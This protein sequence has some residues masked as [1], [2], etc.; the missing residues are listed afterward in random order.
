MTV[1]H[2]RY[3]RKKIHEK[4]HTREHCKINPEPG[5]DLHLTVFYSQMLFIMIGKQF[6]HPEL[7]GP[8]TPRCCKLCQCHYRVDASLNESLEF[9]NL[10]EVPSGAGSLAEASPASSNA[11]AP[12][13]N[14][15]PSPSRAPR[16][17]FGLHGHARDTREA[18]FCLAVG[19]RE[20]ARPGQ[21]RSPPG[22]SAHVICFASF[23]SNTRDSMFSSTLIRAT[24]ATDPI[25]HQATHRKW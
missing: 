18:R 16:P 25:G 23:K 1:S 3:A 7:G 9:A 15:S 12:S 4:T 2:L 5:Q 21:D 13:K 24:Y 20:S 17:T 6:L 19:F 8:G 10:F 14:H 11:P 22:R